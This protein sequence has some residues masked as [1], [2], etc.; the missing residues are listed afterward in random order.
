MNRLPLVS[1][2][3]LAPSTKPHPGRS[4]ISTPSLRVSVTRL[5]AVL[6]CQVQVV[7]APSDALPSSVQSSSVPFSTRTHEFTPRLGDVTVNTARGVG[8]VTASV[9]VL[10]APAYVA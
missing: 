9:V 3:V 8:V 5:F 6:S 7:S 10:A 2:D 4:G 1:V